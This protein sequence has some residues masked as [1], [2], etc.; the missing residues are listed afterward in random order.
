[1]R[2]RHPWYLS[3]SCLSWFPEEKAQQQQPLQVENA[4]LATFIDELELERIIWSSGHRGDLCRYPALLLVRE[5][6]PGAFWVNVFRHLA[7]RVLHNVLDSIQFNPTR[8]STVFVHRIS[9]DRSERLWKQGGD[10][11]GHGCKL[12]LK[13]EKGWIPVDLSAESSSPAAV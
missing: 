8:K 3:P 2:Q 10:S 13:E 11:Q 12:V 7:L 9:P 1:M 4:H 5:P 6:D